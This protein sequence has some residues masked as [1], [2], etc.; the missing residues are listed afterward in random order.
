MGK[1]KAFDCV[2]HDPREEDVRPDYDT[3]KS[4]INR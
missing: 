2:T 4:I 1:A 3:S